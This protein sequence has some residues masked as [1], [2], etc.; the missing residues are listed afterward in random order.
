MIDGGFVRLQW[1]AH[2]PIGLVSRR[3]NASSPRVLASLVHAFI[4]PT[5]LRKPAAAVGCAEI[6][7]GF[8]RTMGYA[9][10]H[11]E[12]LRLAPARCSVPQWL[13]L[14]LRRRSFL[15]GFVWRRRD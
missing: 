14:A 1:V 4:G 8:V 13:R 3:C 7:R 6:R 9:P 15:R 2:R 5:N 10:R 12:W 11:R